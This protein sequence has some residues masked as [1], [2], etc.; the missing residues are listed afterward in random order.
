M[1]AVSAKIP[2]YPP[3]MNAR[4]MSRVPFLSQIPVLAARE[5]LECD[6]VIAVDV[7]HEGL[8]LSRIPRNAIQTAIHLA[9]L[10]ARKNAQWEGEKADCM[11]RVSA[12]GI[13][14]M[15]LGRGAEMVERG[16][17][18]AEEALGRLRQQIAGRRWRPDL[19]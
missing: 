8:D 10:W 1:D 11:I 16:R 12:K 13:S 19:A 6:F 15:D 14:L 5:D 4:V 17:E 7:N 3:E 2:S 9:P 18:A